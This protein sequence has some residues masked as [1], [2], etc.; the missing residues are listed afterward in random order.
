MHQ[1]KNS[2][3]VDN[4][5]SLDTPRD[6]EGMKVVE[7]SAFEKY[8]SCFVIVAPTWWIFFTLMKMLPNVS[9]ICM[10]VKKVFLSV[11]IATISNFPQKCV[12]LR[13][14]YETSQS[15]IGQCE[16]ERSNHFGEKVDF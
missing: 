16:V 13:H 5:A 3:L 1:T 15:K 7:L 2:I 12:L 8:I 4:L 11:S 6:P 14:S 9:F 10:V